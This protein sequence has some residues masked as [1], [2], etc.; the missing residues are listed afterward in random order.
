MSAPILPIVNRTLSLALLLAAAAS[1]LPPLVLVDQPSRWEADW[2]LGQWSI[3]SSHPDKA[4]R[5]PGYGNQTAAGALAVPV[6]EAT[7]ALPPVGTWSVEVI[8]DSMVRLPGSTWLRAPSWTTNPIRSV[9]AAPTTPPAWREETTPQGRILRLSIPWAETEGQ[10]LN[11]ARKVRVVVSMTGTGTEPLSPSLAGFVANPGGAA[12]FGRTNSLPARPFAA[13]GLAAK[14]SVI[15]DGNQSLILTVR[16]PGVGDLSQDGIVRLTGSQIRAQLG[17]L[18]GVDFSKVAVGRHGRGPIPRDADS[19]IHTGAMEALPIRRV[20]LDRDGVFDPE[21]RLEFFAQGPSYWTPDTLLGEGAQE[22]VVHPWD[23][24]RRYLVRL[25]ALDGS[26]DLPMG[27]SPQ[28]PANRTTTLRPVWAGKH[29]QVRVPEI[30]S[31]STPDHES[32]SSWFWHWVESGA[33]DS[34]KLRH[35]ATR[36]LPGLSGS[37]GLGVVRL[38]RVH[39][40]RSVPTESDTLRTYAGSST[41]GM[42]SER[43]VSWNLTGLSPTDNRWIW[44]AAGAESD[45]E[46]YT[47]VYPYAPTRSNLV[48]FPAPALGAF[49]LPISGSSAADTLYAV[50][51]G[52]AERMIVLAGGVLRDSV[53]SLDTWYVPASQAATFSLTSWKTSNQARVLSPEELVSMSTKLDYLIVAPD[54]FLT[55]ASEFAAFRASPTRLRPMETRIVRAEDLWL[56]WGHGS[57]DPLAVRELLRKATRHW[58]TT[59]AV[60]LG[61]GHFDPRGVTGTDPV[62][63]PVWEDQDVG[64]DVI[65]TYLDPREMGASRTRTQDIALGRIPARSREELAAWFSKLRAWEDPSVAVTGPWRNTFLGVADD[66]QV[67]TNGGSPDPIYHP[68]GYLGHT[69]ATERLVQNILSVRPWAQIRKV[70]QVEYP[71]NAVLE[72][73]DAQR[74]LIDQLN[75]GVAAWQFMGHGGFDILTDER[76]LDT[77][78]ALA[79]LTNNETP[80]I[81]YAGSCTVGRF[82]LANNRGLSEAL[83]VAARKGAVA[84]ISGTR[85]SYPDDNERLARNFWIQ[86]LSNESVGLPTTLGEAFQR[87]QNSFTSGA[88]DLQSMYPN[89]TLYNLLGDPAMV[90]FPAGSPLSLESTPDTIA[91]LDATSL[92]GSAE[93]QV[94]VQLVAKAQQQTATY[95]YGDDVYAQTYLSPGRTLVSL[96]TTATSNR[97]AAR[98]LTPARLPFG[99]TATLSVYGWNPTTLR[100]SAVLHEGVVL[101]GIGANPPSDAQGPSIR[102]LPCDS[103]WSAGQP[104]GAVAEIPVPFCLNVFFEDSSGI[105]SSDAPDEGVILSVPGT[106]EPWHPSRL[107]EGAD[108]SQAWTRLSIDEANFTAGKTYT[109][110]VFARDLMGNASSKSIELRTRKAGEVDLYEVFNRPNPVKGD[111]TIFYFKLLADADSNGTVPG[112]VQAAIRIHTLSGKLVR[113]LNT[114]L[115]EAGHPRPRAVWDLRDAFRNN[116]ANGLYP[117]TILLRIRDSESGNWRQLEKRGVIAV[118]R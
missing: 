26:P 36:D 62:V 70:Y 35:P 88:S 32:G 85:P 113:V 25:D 51:D 99:D 14:A 27:V 75:R 104:F 105:S 95:T 49:A 79:G 60:L 17:S 53:A 111:A 31:P 39:L 80:H 33:L 45:F 12:R 59:H 5:A 110:N 28:A 78:S 115:T 21:D 9:P 44:Q 109:L 97:Y 19:A 61:G 50:V 74:A 65:L 67:R 77:R 98:L 22:L 107:E 46:S 42:V 72:K 7:L 93:S 43:K 92:V 69:H 10:G 76:L 54:S 117:Y 38:G 102:V 52:R 20:D 118:S 101:A 114:D 30:G 66:M 68:N 94:Q 112:T 4:L 15:P 83:L 71:A 90:P 24:S 29:L 6:A 108:F 11:L 86:A 87:A 40:D 55:I 63:I 81:F 106:L 47:V 96:R 2:Q 84:A 37:T 34:A 41:L 8:R 82:D 58:A 73:P 64:T 23:L 57:M 91:A 100:D 56:L 3:D 18:S 89:S 16:N 48:A 13:R 1:A 103:S 116:V